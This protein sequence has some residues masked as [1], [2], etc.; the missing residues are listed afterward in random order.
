MADWRAV[1]ELIRARHEFVLLTHVN[2]DGDAIGAQLGLLRALKALGKDARALADT[3]V[4]G[5]YAFLDHQEIAVQRTCDHRDAEVMFAL[6]IA[7]WQR[8][9]ACAGPLLTGR[10]VKVVIDHHP[11][12]DAPPGDINVIAT[13]YTSTSEL[14]QEL[15]EAMGL[16]LTREIAEPLYVGMLTDTGKFSYGNGLSLAHLAA[17]RL[18]ATGVDARAIDDAVYQRSSLARLKL[19]GVTLERLTV[20]AAG[21]LAHTWLTRDDLARAGIAPDDME[22]FIDYIRTL[23]DAEIFIIFWETADGRVKGSMRSRGRVKINKLAEHLGGGGHE[24]AAGFILTTTLTDG[25]PHTLALAEQVLRE[26]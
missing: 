12:T 11:P 18:L 24:F 17:A 19:V 21:R 6:D 13:D 7:T 9:G 3:P 14:V 10:A 5:K 20:T 22:G 15:V 16:P 25:I 2:P 8:L 26:A 23:R 4:P 1:I